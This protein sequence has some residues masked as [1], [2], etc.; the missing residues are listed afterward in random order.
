MDGFG[1]FYVEGENAGAHQVLLHAGVCILMGLG[2]PYL[3]PLNGQI[4]FCR[5]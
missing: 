1:C 5:S 2:S 4:S 3:A